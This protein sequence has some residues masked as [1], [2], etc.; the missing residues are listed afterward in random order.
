[1]KMIPYGKQDIN[2]EDV[3][4]V[5]DIL[6]SDFITM[7][8]TVTRFEKAIAEHCGA[9]FGVSSNSA[10]SA[11]H[12][13]C[14]A[15]GVGAGD[16]VWVAAITFAATANCAVYCGAEV[17]FIDVGLSDYNMDVGVLKQKLEVA[18]SIG[19]LPKVVIPVHL[20]GHSCDMESIHQ[21]SLQYGFK[22]LEDASHAIGGKYQN[23]PVGSCQYSD[24]TVFSFHPVKIITTAEG[25]MAVTNNKSLEEQMRL[26]RSHGITSEPDKMVG[27]PDD[28]IWNYQQ[29]QLGF[30]YRLTDLQAALGLSQLERL[31]DFVKKRNEIAK[32]YNDAFMRLP[33]ITPGQNDKV[34]SS[35][36][37]Y[38]IRIEG[39]QG[40][41]NQRQLYKILQDSKIN[42]NLHYIP[43]Y[44]HPYY[45]AKGF[46]Q[47][48]CLNAETYFK[49]ALS[50]PM[51]PTLSEEE[52][53]YVIG[54]IKNA[55][56]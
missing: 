49:E 18:K 1:M 40:K 51:F 41:I 10:T 26:A 13:A 44:R 27:M 33:V 20:A 12:I 53:E 55:V 39:A 5:I 34:Y 36:H 43:V 24:I 38:I 14:L 48:H 21:L 4:A 3:K 6:K 32:I 2:D 29:V 28:E 42:C 23:R 15:L 19:K 22:I 7:G 45:Q 25:G 50:I 30:N 35:F 52:Q 8:P 47:N 37:L 46:K 16:T 17:D 56:T 11:L 9:K 54:T 31:D